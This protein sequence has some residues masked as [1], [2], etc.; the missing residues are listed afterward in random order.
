MGLNGTAR[1]WRRS[2]DAKRRA[3]TLQ[4]VHDFWQREACGE[5]YGADQDRVR[6]EREPEIIS[7]AEFD[8][9]KGKDVLEIGVGMG[10]DF[11]RW[12]R[13]G[14]RATGV[15]LTERAVE[16]TRRRVRDEG[17]EADVRVA[18][19][20]ALPFPD[21]SFDLVYSWGVLHHT[22][23]TRQALREAV[24]VLR[25]GGMLKVMIYHRHSWVAAAA[26]ARFCLLRG[27][28]LE[29][30]SAAVADMESPGT[31]A[32]T[33]AEARSMLPSLRDLQTRTP[34]TY[35]DRRMA[36]FA[37]WVWPD[38]LGWFLLVEGTKPLG[39]DL[40]DVEASSPLTGPREELA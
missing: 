38:R 23:D 13:S 15:D 12:L 32:F 33:A 40:C 28:P 11:V 3:G 10:A 18:N 21:S 30:M 4:T 5:R 27:R 8:K 25:P 24:R 16:I 17:F 26:W 20:E 1:S 35:W 31:K 37:R 39:E 2:R 9:A 7:F 36:P 29:G 34:C 14:A 6:Y 19:A 22:P